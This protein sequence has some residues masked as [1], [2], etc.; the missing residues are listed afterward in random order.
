MEEVEINSNGGP[1]I[2][3]VD[4]AQ[5]SPRMQEM[6][7]DFVSSGWRLVAETSILPKSEY[8][9]A[10][11]KSTRRLHDPLEAFSLIFTRELFDLLCVSIAKIFGILHISRPL[12]I[13][14]W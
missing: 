2:N 6:C 1:N 7:A 8:N 11:F 4:L 10:V 14:N 12:Q 13:E 3:I 9:Y 5:K